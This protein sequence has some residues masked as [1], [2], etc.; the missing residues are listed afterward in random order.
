MDGKLVRDQIPQVIRGSGVTPRGYVAG[1]QEYR[2]RLRN[3]LDEEVA[4]FLAADGSS[5][6]GELADVMEV[7]HALAADLGVDP[8]ELEKIRAVKASERCG[9]AGRVVWMGN[10]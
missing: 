5:A 9:F 1:P 4:E 6:P 8:A 7:V 10:R 2:W 3:K